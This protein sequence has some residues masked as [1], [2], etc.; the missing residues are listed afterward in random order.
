MVSS[1]DIDGAVTIHNLTATQ[2]F[3]SQF[4]GPNSYGNAVSGLFVDSNAEV[5][6]GLNSNSQSV[7]GK[8]AGE[9]GIKHRGVCLFE[10][11]E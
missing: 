5:V 6:L 8:V 7:W 9:M 1:E 2:L 10:T 3:L 11:G 4:F